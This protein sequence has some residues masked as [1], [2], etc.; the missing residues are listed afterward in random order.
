M[1]RFVFTL[2]LLTLILSACG[3]TT[4][5]APS[6]APTSAP[7]GGIQVDI[8]HMVNPTLAYEVPAGEGFVIDATGYDFGIAG[9]PT[10]VQVIL[11]GREYLGTWANS[12]VT[13]TV[14]A[15]ELLPP[16]GFKPLT[17]FARGAQLI[18]AVGRTSAN[19]R[20]EPLW[21]ATVNVR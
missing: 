18:V 11:D 2:A 1:K 10:A 15:A 19:G 3:T 13:Q 20:F 14:R 4:T 21:V 9:G 17:D 8:E 7:L 16:I 6:P 5:A 12:A